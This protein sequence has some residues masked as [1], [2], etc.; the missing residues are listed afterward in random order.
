MKY[1]N[2]SII[3]SGNVA[4]HLALKLK[5][6]GHKI[7]DIY[8]RK[9]INAEKLANK[10]A[11]NA[12]NDISKINTES[13]II[14]ICVSDKAIS[15]ITN[16]INFEPKLIA[17]TAGSISI[18]E[19]ARFNNHGVF[20]PFQTLTKN[21][22]ITTGDI[23]FCIEANSSENETT[24]LN[25]AK[26]ISDRVM[27]LASDQRKTCHLAAVFACNF[28]NH[29]YAIAEDIL[30]Q[31]HIPFDI[32]KPLILETAQKVQNHSPL[33]SQTGPA[34]RNDVNVMK[35]HQSELSSV[36]LEKMYSFVSESIIELKK[37]TDKQ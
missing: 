5:N 32:L 3:G 22:E 21:S 24:L 17:H 6:A 14:L 35:Q 12:I 4:T 11:S 7:L 31:H 15:E 18:K 34:S 33:L 20:Y 1:Q 25:L 8:S 23:P 27:L 30:Q 16:Q 36:H 13:D 26:S 10:V 29:M 28:T 9:I 37:R 19:L 2:I